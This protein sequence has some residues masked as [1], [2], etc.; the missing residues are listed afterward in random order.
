MESERLASVSV[1]RCRFGIVAV[2]LALVYV[3]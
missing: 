3:S 2:L 1:V